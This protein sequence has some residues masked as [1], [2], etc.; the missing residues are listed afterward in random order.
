M[1]ETRLVLNRDGEAFAL[2]QFDMNQ[3]IEDTSNFN[4]NLKKWYRLPIEKCGSSMDRTLLGDKNFKQIK[5]TSDSI[6]LFKV[7]EKVCYNYQSHNFALLGDWEA[8]D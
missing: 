5:E 4:G 3:Y 7:I 6:G 8:M 1:G 2:Y